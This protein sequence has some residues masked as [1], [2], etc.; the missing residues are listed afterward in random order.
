MARFNRW[1]AAGVIC[2][3]LCASGALADIPEREINISGATL[4]T[5]FFLAPASTNDWIDADGDGDYGCCPPDQL[6]MDSPGDCPNEWAT[7]WIVQYR[8]VGSGNGLAEFVDYQLLA[9]VPDDLPS[10]EGLCN[11]LQWAI[12]GV[13]QDHG[14]ICNM[15][16]WDPDELIWDPNNPDYPPYEPPLLPPYTPPGW[17]DDT[18]LAW[19]DPNVADPNDAV[20]L[21]AGDEIP[22]DEYFG[23]GTR[24]PWPDWPWPWRFPWPPEGPPPPPPPPWNPNMDCCWSKTPLC[25]GS[26][27]LA[28]MD[29]PTRWFVKAG[30][31]GDAAWDTNPGSSGYGHCPTKSWDEGYKNTLKSLERDWCGAKETISLNT[32]TEAPDA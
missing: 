25:W 1:T 19:E 17:W 2:A 12:D 18:C 4:F 27:D 21:W 11:R 7:W 20:I 13:P 9:L 22:F 32:N 16:I 26:V 24:W 28:V 6:A 15:N 8:G 30:G 10:E 5:N 14:C 3:L 31:A 29:V 23:T